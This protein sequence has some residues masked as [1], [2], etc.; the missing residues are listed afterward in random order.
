MFL[1]FRINN[2][3]KIIVGH[4]NVNFFPDKLDA[5]KT[6]IP[7]NIDIM[8]FSK[9]KLDASYPTSQFFI[10]GFLNP[11]RLDR[12]SNWVFLYMLEKIYRY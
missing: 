5:I 2:L 3:N 6:I 12:N 7:S 10:E 11:F 8:I 1:E 9:T 4:L